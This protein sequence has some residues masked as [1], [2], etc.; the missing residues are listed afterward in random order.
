MKIAFITAVIPYKENMGG[1]SGH[2][3][4]L[5][6]ERPEGIEVDI[7]SYN[8]NKSNVYL[9]WEVGIFLHI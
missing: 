3:Y 6:V 1:P 7:Y 9:V 2:P 5:L 4:H 8:A